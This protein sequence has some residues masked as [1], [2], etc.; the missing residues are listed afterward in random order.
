MKRTFHVGL[1]L[2]AVA[3]AASGAEQVL[4]DFDKPVDVAALRSD[5]VKVSFVPAGRGRAMRMDTGH[6]RPWP[7]VTLPAPAG[8]WDLSK[9]EYVAVDVV[10]VGKRAVRVYC[11]VDNPGADGR[12]NCTTSSL[13]LGP[14]SRGTIKASLYSG[15][16]RL[17]PPVQII[18]MRGTPTG[19]GPLDPANVTQLLI[20]V[21]RPKTDHA[22][23]IDN[24]RAGG[25]ARV[26]SAKDFFPFIDEFGQYIHKDWPG[27]THSTA[28]L[29]K[30]RKA[31]AA[32]LAAH[33]G[34]KGW[35]T[36]G[37]WADGPTLDA[38]GFFHA[39]KH[40]GKWWLVDPEGRLFWSHGADCVR[41][42]H[43]T[44]PITDR[45]HYFKDLPAAGSPF[46][47]FYGK[48]SWG[49]HGYYKGKTYESFSFSCAN[50]L[51]KYGPDWR[52]AYADV[53]HRRIRS[54]AMNTIGNWS[55][56]TIRLKRRTP[57]VVDIHCRSRP[58][59]GSKGY[60]RQFPDVFD[61]GFRRALRKRLDREKHSTAGDAWCIGYF[62]DNELSWGSETSL[63]EAAL[64][65][66]P[67]QPAKT[68]FVADLKAK[69]GAVD[70]L[71]AAWGARH[72][73]WEA[74]PASRAAPDRRRAGADLKAFTTRIAETYFRI[75]RE[76]VKRIAPKNMYLGCRFAWVND[77]A[78]TAAA[79][80]CDAI[81]YNLYR[82][83]VAGFRPGGGVDRPV[84]VGE[85]HFGALDRG[86][87]HTGLRPTGSQNERAARYKSY[88]R[89][90]LRNPYLV[91]THWFQYGDQATTGRGDGENYQIGFVDVCD[92]PYPE[93]VAA[94]RQVGADMYAYRLKGE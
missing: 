9:R 56:E 67:D 57:Y 79:K 73:S 70:K 35:N 81:G 52:T 27:K 2:A 29:A 8:T 30:H 78:A 44:T 34:P 71:N 59:E 76:E 51:R 45:K 66:P 13:A 88:V 3:C 33:P 39:A 11:R 5:D 75:C 61:A 48:G 74:L 92:T 43:A 60:W 25:T 32:D 82:D 87:F 42:Y 38:T 19:P 12:R 17:V 24:V 62:V 77:R 37:G 85:F 53:T 94:A 31:E 90:A 72:A 22:F 16:V 36:Y 68:A 69:Y 18:G 93:T 63:A 6:T 89:G 21:A 23:T 55:D 54:W 14:G 64:A 84:I 47:R 50:L 28:D 49:P 15:S 91:G 4:Y 80:Y 26:M 65:S 40:K 46:V 58:I 41:P 10:N 83:D 7:G 86:M 20:F 1:L